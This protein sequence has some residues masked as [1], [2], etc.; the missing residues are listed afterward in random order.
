MCIWLP[1]YE[2]EVKTFSDKVSVIRDGKGDEQVL[3]QY[4]KSLKA[5]NERRFL[6]KL[7]DVPIVANI[8]RGKCDKNYIE[9]YRFGT[10]QDKADNDEFE[11]YSQ[12][13]RIS[14]CKKII[15]A[16]AVAHSRNIAH[17]DLKLSNIC[18]ASEDITDI[19]I[20]DFEDSYMVDDDPIIS[21]LSMSIEYYSPEIYMINEEIKHGRIYED[22][23]ILYSIDVWSI[24]VIIIKILME[25]NHHLM[26]NDEVIAL[27]CKSGMYFSGLLN[28]IFTR[29]HEERPSIFD[30][31][32]QFA[33]LEALC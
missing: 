18:V 12:K 27:I 6:Y 25:R 30:L 13:I 32:K 20:I 1:S 24:G 26:L 11:I 21:L 5:S 3:K 16:V 9:Y 31:Q 22:K 10:L 15:D 28:A 19:R 14:L 23:R 7:A 29:N 8:I 4:S 2:R 17:L 33:A